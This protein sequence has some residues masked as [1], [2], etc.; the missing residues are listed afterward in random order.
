[1][2]N[3]I[4][5]NIAEWSSLNTFSVLFIAVSNWELERPTKKQVQSSLFKQHYSN[6]IT[7]LKFNHFES[8]QICIYI[9]QYKNALKWGTESGE[10]I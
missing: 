3:Y 7:D 8:K 4:R 10:T 1:M 9:F 5:A 2:K 6:F